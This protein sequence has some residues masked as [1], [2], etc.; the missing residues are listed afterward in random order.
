MGNYVSVT[1]T[2]E[3]T[4]GVDAI[5][6]PFDP[7]PV[8]SSAPILDPI[9]LPDALTDPTVEPTESLKEYT[10]VEPEIPI[11]SKYKDYIGQQNEWIN[12]IRADSTLLK[13]VPQYLITSEMCLIAVKNDF[14]NI[15][16]VPTDIMNQE[17]MMEIANATNS[18]ILNNIDKIINSCTW[19]NKIIFLPHIKPELKDETLLNKLLEL[20]YSLSDLI[21]DESFN[22][23]IKTNYKSV[24][25]FV[26]KHHDIESNVPVLSLLADAEKTIEVCASRCIN[27]SNHRIRLR[28]LRYLPVDDIG[29]KISSMCARLSF[30][31]YWTSSISSD[32]LKE[33][34]N[35]KLYDNAV[36]ITKCPPYMPNEYQQHE[37]IKKGLAYKNI[38]NNVPERFRT[39]GVCFCANKL[40]IF[41][42]TYFPNPVA[43]CAKIKELKDKFDGTTP[44][45]IEI[46]YQ[47]LIKNL[48]PNKIQQYMYQ[49]KNLVHQY[50][51]SI[52][53]LKNLTGPVNIYNFE[54]KTMTGADFN[55]FTKDSTLVKL[56][57]RNK[58]HNDMEF[59]LGLNTDPLP[60]NPIGS[61][62]RG[63]I[64]FVEKQNYERWVQYKNKVMRYFSLVVIPDDAQVYIEKDKF[65]ADKINVIA[66]RSLKL[67]PSISDSNP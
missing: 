37:Y 61:C 53:E 14:Y 56:F 49:Y 1:P 45:E 52:A 21:N 59:K 32:Y 25:D 62:K 55:Y 48:D 42:S 39:F 51:A 34:L 66:F 33:L 50:P 31:P 22:K 58:V 8:D 27:L 43:T 19:V 41:N 64:Y 24:V 16:F 46:E 13:I 29:F 9:Q 30:S 12:K 26:L 5:L 28:E 67:L 60:F 15:V 47:I 35:Q 65:K 2:P 10:N 3:M 6:E 7:K 57:T 11:L 23:L 18:A 38:L 54:G 4:F 36:S 40:S 17:I 44:A 63:G 20:K